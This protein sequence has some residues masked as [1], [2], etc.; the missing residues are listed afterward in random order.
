MRPFLESACNFQFRGGFKIIIGHLG[1]SKS[2]HNHRHSH[3]PPPSFALH[4]KPVLA[5][6]VSRGE[7][8]GGRV[9]YMVHKL[10]QDMK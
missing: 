10:G 7:G 1:A 6:N 5:L 8:G 3:P 2:H 9:L 4:A